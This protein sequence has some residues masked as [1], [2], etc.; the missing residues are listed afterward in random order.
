[1]CIK[2]TD[3][4]LFPLTECQPRNCCSPDSNDTLNKRPISG[5][6]THLSAATLQKKQKKQ[7]HTHKHNNTKHLQNCQKKKKQKINIFLSRSSPQQPIRGHSRSRW[8]RT[9]GWTTA[10]CGSS[11]GNRSPAG[12]HWKWASGSSAGLPKD[13][14]VERFHPFGKHKQ[15]PHLVRFKSQCF[16]YLTAWPKARV[17]LFSKA[18][19]QATQMHLHPAVAAVDM[20]RGNHVNHK[21]PNCVDCLL[22]T[23]KKTVFKETIF[24]NSHSSFVKD[25]SHLISSQWLAETVSGWQQTLII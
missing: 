8:R 11:H 22:S 5:H 2:T 10:R 15:I 20:W 7:N 24:I 14:A 6:Y 12:S 25:S 16:V 4:A 18:D 21:R 3:R 19:N 13:W 9:G 23:K 17:A 1:M